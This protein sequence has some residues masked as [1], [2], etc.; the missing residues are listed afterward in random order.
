VTLLRVSLFS[1]TVE[2][3]CINEVYTDTERRDEVCFA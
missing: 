3:S 1:L 2:T